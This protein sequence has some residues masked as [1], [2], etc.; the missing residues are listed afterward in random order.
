MKSSGELWQ[1]G[2]VTAYFDVISTGVIVLNIETTNGAVAIPVDYSQ[3]P[4][5]PRAF[6]DAGHGVIDDPLDNIALHGP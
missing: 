2:M 6:Q 5:L 3:T 4:L 1:E